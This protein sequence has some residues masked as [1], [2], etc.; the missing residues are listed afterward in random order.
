MDSLRGKTLR[1]TFTDGPA[2][3]TIFEHDF[4]QDGSV[5]W[6]VTEG[7]GKGHTG[8]EKRYSALQAGEGILAVSYLATSGYTLTVVLNQAS[9]RL[10]GFASN[11]A[12][13]Y[14]MMGTFEVLQ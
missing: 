11:N 10:V 8:Q 7:V 13:W 4:H 2:A 9:G 12:E 14:P 3:G 6:R 5:D 1:W